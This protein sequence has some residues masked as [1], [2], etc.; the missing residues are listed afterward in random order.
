MANY[1]FSDLK[2]KTV[3]L[4]GGFG[5]I[6]KALCQ[7]FV[8]IGANLIIADV[9]K[10]DGYIKKLKKTNIGKTEYIKF[11]MTKEEEIST[12]VEIVI[13][14]FGKIDVLVNCSFP[15]TKDW[16]TDVEHV[17]YQS[18][19]ENLINHLGG[20]YNVTQKVALQ[21]KKQKYGSIINFSSTYGLVAP[22]FSIYERTK[23]TSAPAYALIKGGINTMTR[24]FA[25][26]FGKYNIRINCVSSG[27]VFDNQDKKFVKEYIR[28]TPLGRMA[29]PNDLVM[30][31]LFLASDGSKYITGHNLLVDGGWTIH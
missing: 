10:D 15:R 21:M 29:N 5:F 30:P 12:L 7:G 13:K 22:T 31:V 19:K 26:Y 27:G 28:L 1:N 2:G 17:S 16:E 9:Y 3:I 11:N 23:M 25:S 18:V 4:V 20:Y 6:G 14:K 24:Y 8:S